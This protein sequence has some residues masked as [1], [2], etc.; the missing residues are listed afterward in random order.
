MH[1]I[2][3]Y[4]S[5][6]EQVN[7]RRAV[8]ESGLSR[9]EVVIPTGHAYDML[10]HPRFNSGYSIVDSFGGTAHFRKCSLGNGLLDCVS[11]SPRIH[12]HYVAGG[13]IGSETFWE[14]MQR[15][16]EDTIH[17]ADCLTFTGDNLP[18]GE[19]AFV[20]SVSPCL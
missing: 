12:V 1:P 6:T 2:L 10:D 9:N 13:L 20:I 4:Y 11:P 3:L 16:W 17:A 18:H 14:Y 8:T 5:T 7:R 15:H 19:S